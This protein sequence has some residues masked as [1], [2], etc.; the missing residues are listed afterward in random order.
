MPVFKT[1]SANEQIVSSLI[2]IAFTAFYWHAGRFIVVWFRKRVKDFKDIPKS[3]FLQY[4][5]I[6]SFVVGFCFI[7]GVCFN[8]C[9]AGDLRGGTEDPAAFL[10]AS[11]TATLIICGIYEAIYFLNKW[12]NSHTEAERLKKENMR[13]QLETLQNQVNPHFLFNSLNTLASIIPEDPK[14][15]VAFVQHLSNVYRCILEIK[16]KQV[17]TIREELECIKSYEFLLG[18]RFGNNLSI[19]RDITENTMDRFIVPLSLQ[20]LLENALKHNIASKKQP[21]IITFNVEGNTL[22]V[23][24]NLQ[25]KIEPST[26]TKTGLSNIRSRYKLLVNK[27]IEVIESDEEFIVKLPIIEISAI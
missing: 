11:I 16:D 25:P 5:A 8:L 2:S 12:K 9:G 27:D 26:S 17:I 6:L 7:S 20:I 19:H 23:R 13:G 22:I 24:N 15:A 3:L 14:T 21:L 10:L 18:I 1:L 4:L